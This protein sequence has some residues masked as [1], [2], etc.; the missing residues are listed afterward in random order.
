MSRATGLA[1]VFAQCRTPDRQADDVRYWVAATNA[2]L[3]GLSREVALSK[4]QKD[5]LAQDLAAKIKFGQFE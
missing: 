5:E 4:K 1:P 2:P 3:A